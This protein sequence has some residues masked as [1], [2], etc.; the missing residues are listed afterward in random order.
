[1]FQLCAANGKGVQFG[2]AYVL[3]SGDAQFNA[4]NGEQVFRDKAEAAAVVALNNLCASQ[5]NDGETRIVGEVR[6]TPVP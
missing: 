6:P 5:S 1:M 2:R 3:L 4:F